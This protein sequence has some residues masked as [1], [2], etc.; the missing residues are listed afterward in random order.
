MNVTKMKFAIK[1]A[2]VVLITLSISYFGNQFY[3]EKMNIVGVD[4]SYI[5]IG[6]NNSI[7]FISWMIYP[8]VLSYVFWIFTFFMIAYYDPLR[9]TTLY[10]T[11]IVTLIICGIWYFFFQSDVEAWRV[12]SGLFLDNDY[13]KPITN[14]NF[15][16]KLVLLIYSGA[17]PR[18]ALPS[19]HVL[20]SWITI[21]AARRNCKYPIA[22]RYFIVSM[23]LTII[24]STQTVKQHYIIDLIAAIIIAEA[25]Y[26]FFVYYG[27]K[28]FD[29]WKILMAKK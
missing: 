4:Y 3:A 18:N 20:L 1:P 15:T 19:M 2:I 25:T 29:Q 9:F 14:P 27:N 23:G 24:I 17:G 13:S 5:F 8:Y 28:L 21:I 11:I 7:P 16:E 26:W 10:R 6:I 12:T 22:L